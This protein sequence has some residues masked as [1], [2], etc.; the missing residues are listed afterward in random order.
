[1]GSQSFPNMHPDLEVGNSMDGGHMGLSSR[2]HPAM[3]NLHLGSG[4]NGGGSS[5]TR[6]GG[7]NSSSWQN[8]DWQ[9]GFRALLPNVNVSFGPSNSFMEGGPP[10]PRAPPLPG[11]PQRNNNSSNNSSNSL[12]NAVA[13]ASVAGMSMPNREDNHMGMVRQRSVGA[14]HHPSMA[15]RQHSKWATY[16]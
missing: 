5:N 11:F 9:D 10:H 12:G 14:P 4:G 7:Q 16:S 15:A 13:A 6:S 8:K 1:M 2:L 3:S